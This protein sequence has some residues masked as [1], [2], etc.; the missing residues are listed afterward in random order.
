MYILRIIM[1]DPLQDP[2]K[3]QFFQDLPLQYNI[4]FPKLFPLTLQTLTPASN[5]VKT[6]ILNKTNARF[7][8]Q[9]Q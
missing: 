2:T 7:W 5:Q 6:N 4:V 9:A 1:C 3:K 8:D